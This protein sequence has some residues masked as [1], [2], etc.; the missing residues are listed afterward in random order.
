MKFPSKAF[1][2]ADRAAEDALVRA[3]RE[4]AEEAVAKAGLAGR[5]LAQV[6]GRKIAEK[7]ASFEIVVSPI[8]E[9]VPQTR[10]RAEFI[11]RMRSFSRAGVEVAHLGAGVRG[12]G[13]D[14]RV[15]VLGWIAGALADVTHDGTQPEPPRL[16]VIE[17]ATPEREYVAVDARE[18]GD[19]IVSFGFEPAENRPGGRLA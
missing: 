3:L 6:R 4:G 1:A 5:V 8:V 12:V 15:R 19:R 13:D 9:G 11:R 10:E 14:G 17:E 18:V 2:L 7:N 16:V